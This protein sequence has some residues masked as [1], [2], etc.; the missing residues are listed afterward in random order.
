[1]APYS[2][3][4]IRNPSRTSD[5]TTFFAVI[6][7]VGYSWMTIGYVLSG[8]LAPYTVIPSLETS[9]ST[10]TPETSI[11]GLVSWL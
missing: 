2:F 10:E 4:L 11:D 1:M 5:E 6:D 8:N 3:N 7:P 9:V